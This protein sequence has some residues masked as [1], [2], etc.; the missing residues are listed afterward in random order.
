MD[1]WWSARA[2]AR[3]TS[4]SGD[5]RYFTNGATALDDPN[6]T[7]LFPQ[8][9]HLAM[10]S[11]KC[12]L[13]LSFRVLVNFDNMGT[14]P[15]SVMTAKF[16]SFHQ[17]RYYLP[18]LAMLD[19]AAHTLAR[20]SGCSD[21][22]SDTINSKPPTNDLTIS[23]ASFANM[24]GYSNYITMFNAW[25]DSPCSGRLHLMIRR[26]EQRPEQTNAV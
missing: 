25:R 12:F 5:F 20:T 1:N 14:T 26:F 2:V 16:S 24:L 4:W 15:W 10:A 18:S 7:L 8:W 17:S 13:S 19:M 22:N 21:F 3:W 11:A 9:Q 23:P 6:A